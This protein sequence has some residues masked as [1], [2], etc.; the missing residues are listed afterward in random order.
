[1]K[2]SLEDQIRNRIKN[3]FSC[4]NIPYAILRAYLSFLIF[5]GDHRKKKKITFTNMTQWLSKLPLKLDLFKKN[6]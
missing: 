6:P 1:M 4:R 2:T 5:L 3:I